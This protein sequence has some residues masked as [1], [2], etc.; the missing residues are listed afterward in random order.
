[1]LT[2]NERG[3]E[4]KLENALDICKFIHLYDIHYT[5]TKTQIQLVMKSFGL[6]SSTF[7][8]AI[9]GELFLR[10]DKLVDKASEILRSLP[11]PD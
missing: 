4:M 9:C 7:R 8:A 6:V 2:L 1:M 11:Y 3:H 10:S 5:Y